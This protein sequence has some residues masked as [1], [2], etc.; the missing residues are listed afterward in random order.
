MHANGM[1]KGP[2]FVRSRTQDTRRNLPRASA[3]KR[4]ESNFLRKFERVYFTSEG[5]AKIASR[6]FGVEGFGRP[7]LV[8][9][10]W[11]SCRTSQDFTALALKRRVRLTAIEGKITDWRKGLQQAFRYRYFAHRALLVLPMDAARIAVQHLGTFRRLRVG[12]WA[13]DVKSGRIRKW[14]TPR[15]SSPLNRQAWEKAV[16]VF[17]SDLNF[18]KLTELL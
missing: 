2:A 17:E 12:L 3:Q 18:R 16:H 14:C 5:A 10:A 9:L 1:K 15:A 4:T 7:D 8:W 6:E 13:F 11:R